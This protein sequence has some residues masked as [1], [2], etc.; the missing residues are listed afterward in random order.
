MEEDR[1]NAIKFIENYYNN[2]RSSVKQI[3]GKYQQLEEKLNKLKRGSIKTLI[4]FFSGDIDLKADSI[5]FS[6]L[7]ERLKEPASIKVKEVKEV[8]EVNKIKETKEIPQIH[9]A[10]V[11]RQPQMIKKQPPQQRPISVPKAGATQVDHIFNSIDQNKLGEKNR[12]K[13]RKSI[14]DNV[15][16]HLKREREES[17]PKQH[18]GKYNYN[19]NPMVENQE[20]R[21]RVETTKFSC[22][23]PTQQHEHKSHPSVGDL[24][25]QQK[26]KSQE[27][28]SEPPVSF[29]NRYNNAQK[30]TAS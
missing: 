19:V 26:D 14:F 22:Q 2:L 27:K 8:K 25:S 16:P 15:N 1:E 3:K 23:L 11:E 12:E 17:R 18:S 24:R 5:E 7:M 20:E 6:P 29:E 28:E 13:P 10:R 9:V 21:D 30:F 4:F